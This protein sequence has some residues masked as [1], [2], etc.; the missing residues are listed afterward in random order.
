MSDE[1]GKINKPDSKEIIGKRKA[2]VY[3]KFDPHRIGIN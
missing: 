2:F 3:L 1:I